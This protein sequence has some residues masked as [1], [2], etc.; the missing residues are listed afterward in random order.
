[1][2][3]P[4]QPA[5]Y[6]VN[7]PVSRYLLK[8]RSEEIGSEVEKSL[9]SNETEVTIGPGDGLKGNKKYQYTVT[10]VNDVGN[11]TSDTHVISKYSKRQ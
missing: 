3:N 7:Y 8:L 1:M 5:L 9:G 2:F 4:L 10:A 11:T 6:C